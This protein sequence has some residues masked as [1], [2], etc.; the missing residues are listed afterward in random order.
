MPVN[1]KRFCECGLL[2]LE[3]YDT[4]SSQIYFQANSSYQHFEI[5]KKKG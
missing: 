2:I 5:T 3:S 4:L 1:N